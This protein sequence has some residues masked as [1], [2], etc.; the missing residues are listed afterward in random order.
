[1][2]YLQYITQ[3]GRV[4]RGPDAVLCRAMPCYAMLCYAVLLLSAAD[5][6]IT[7]DSIDGGRTSEPTKGRAS[8]G[9]VMILIN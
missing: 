2:A 6:R 8:S 4:F 7:I 1:M 3:L 9:P 5:Y